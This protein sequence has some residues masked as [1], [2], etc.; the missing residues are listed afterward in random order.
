MEDIIGT[1]RGEPSQFVDAKPKQG[2]RPE[3][4][5]LDRQAHGDRRSVPPRC[6]KALEYRALRGRFI[7]MVGLWVEFGREP[8]DVLARATRFSGLLKRMPRTRSSNHS[9]IVAASRSPKNYV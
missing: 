2:V 6:R 8:L 1:H 7:E 3:R 4:A 9:T 5:R